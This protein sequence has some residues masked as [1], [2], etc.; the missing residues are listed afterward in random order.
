MAT[1]TRIWA[2]HTL[3]NDLSVAKA[4]V[5]ITL[6]PSAHLIHAAIV[7]SCLSTLCFRG[8]HF[9]ATA[10]DASNVSTLFC[11]WHSIGLVNH[12][13]QILAKSPKPCDRAFGYFE[14]TV[15]SALDTGFGPFFMKLGF[16]VMPF[17]HILNHRMARSVGLTS[18]RCCSNIGLLA[19]IMQTLL[20]RKCGNVQITHFQCFGLSIVDSSSETFL[21]SLLPSEVSHGV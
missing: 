14:L 19:P 1:T 11:V 16:K 15:P 5:D 17:Q 10:T 8:T 12:F 4:T 7:F 21:S 3:P 6:V 9:I 13:H 2:L 18:A 20:N